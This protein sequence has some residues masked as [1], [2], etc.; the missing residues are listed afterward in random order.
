[1]PRKA[2][3]SQRFWEKVS[4]GTPG[5]C[6]LWIGARTGK[7]TTSVGGYGV[8]RL[9]KDGGFRQVYAHQVSYWLHYGPVSE[10]IEIDH[11]CSNRLC[12]NPG[13]LE[14]VTS[15]INTRR[16]HE[17]GNCPNHYKYKT[18]C[19]NGHILSGENLVLRKNSVG[20][21]ARICKEC[22]RDRDRKRSTRR[23]RR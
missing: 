6:W 2:P 3:L 17:R 15:L 23:R 12:V 22:R 1:M 8:I 11:L 18:H 4:K 7:S 19:R 5:E 14:A 13:H 16:I 20:G 9:G 21:P 10:D